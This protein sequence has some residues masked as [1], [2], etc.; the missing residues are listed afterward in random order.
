MTNGVARNDDLALK[1]PAIQ[2]SGAGTIDLP[3]RRL[4]Y[5]VQPAVGIAGANIA[6]PVLI[7]GPWSNISYRP[8]LKAMIGQ[9]L[10]KA[11]GSLIQAVK[12][13][14]GAGAAGAG[15]VLKGLFGGK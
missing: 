9:N 13:A 6:V 14:G 1:S 11:G 5:R 2:L 10:G 15:A 8:D 3:Q 12:G 7:T 4:D